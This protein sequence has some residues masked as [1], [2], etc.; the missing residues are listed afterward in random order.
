[1]EVSREELIVFENSEAGGDNRRG[2]VLKSSK[3][4]NFN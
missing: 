3:L 4:V 2:R 1:M